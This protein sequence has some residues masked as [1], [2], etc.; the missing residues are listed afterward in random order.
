[1]NW[2]DYL[3]PFWSLWPPFLFSG[4][5]VKI[6][7]KDFRHIRTTLKLRFYT[8]NFVGTQFGG[9]LFA[10]TDPPY[11]IML[12]KNLGPQ[13]SIWDKSATIRYLKPGRTHVTAEFILTEDDLN[14]I[15]TQLQ[16][17][18]RIIW[19]RTVQIKDLNGEVVAEVDKVI[20]IKKKGSQ[21]P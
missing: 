3:L 7:S 15:R 1:M 11:M 5:R 2:R 19:E 4:I 18:D 21:R 20:S 8:A 6:L 14:E 13:Y 12:I 17:K 9:S 10:M 16:D